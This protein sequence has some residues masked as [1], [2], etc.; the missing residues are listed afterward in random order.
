METGNNSYFSIALKNNGTLWFFGNNSYS[1]DAGFMANNTKYLIPTSITPSLIWKD[2]TTGYFRIIGIHD[3]NTLWGW[4]NNDGGCLGLSVNMTTVKTPTQI[5]VDSDW[6][7]VSCGLFHTLALKS[8]GTLWACGYNN[9]VQLGNGMSGTGIF[10]DV[11][12]QI[13]I[14]NNRLLNEYASYRWDIVSTDRSTKS[15]EAH[16]H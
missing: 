1:T 7:K 5:G 11:F 15:K 2:I 4:G 6:S 9:V 13:G 16:V 10:S 8:N 14:D 12:V 3:N